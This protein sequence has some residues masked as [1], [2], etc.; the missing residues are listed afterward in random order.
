[1]EAAVVKAISE[2]I[3]MEFF[4]A[5]AYGYLS[6][7]ADSFGLPGFSKHFREEMDAECKHAQALSCLLTD[8]GCEQE[9]V[10]GQYEMRIP[11]TIQDMVEI[12]ASLEENTSAAINAIVDLYG[13]EK[14]AF[15]I[16]FAER[17][18]K[19]TAEAKRLLEQ[20]NGADKAALLVIDYG[21]RG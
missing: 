8:L 1:M 17:Q 14:E 3:A 5:R 20:V 10:G 6:N 11:Y 4:N 16:A 9:F 2:Q 15:F 19:D 7:R 12:A 18:A 21:L 13:P